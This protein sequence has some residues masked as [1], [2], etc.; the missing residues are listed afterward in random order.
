MDHAFRAAYTRARHALARHRETAL[1]YFD[2]KVA[3]VVLRAAELAVEDRL[4]NDTKTRPTFRVVSAPTGSGKTSCTMAFIAAKLETDP[5]FSAAII[6]ETCLNCDDVYCDLVR[7]V[8][9]EAVSVWTT[10]H[11]V[12]TD[13]RRERTI[14][15]KTDE[16][17]EGAAIKTRR[18]DLLQAR[19]AICTHAAWEAEMETERNELRK[20]R[21]P[22]RS[23]RGA[24]HFRD[25]RRTVLFVDEKPSLSRLFEVQSRHV[26]DLKDALRDAKN[27]PMQVA[28]LGTLYARMEEAANAPQSYTYVPVT[29]VTP[30]EAEVFDHFSEDLAS[31]LS[32]RSDDRANAFQELVGFIKTAALGNV[33][34]SQQGI[35]GKVSFV[36]YKLAYDQDP[37]IVLLDATADLD[38]YCVLSEDFARVECPKARYDNMV[39]VN[40]LPPVLFSK[41]T[42]YIDQRSAWSEYGEWAYRLVMDHTE[43]GER[44]LVIVHKELVKQSE[45]WETTFDDKRTLDFEGRSI[46]CITWGAGIGLNKWTKCQKVFAIGEFIPPRSATVAETEAQRRLK[47]ELEELA[48]AQGRNFTGHYLLAQEGH[49][50]RWQVQLAL[51]G[52][53]R[54]LDEEGAASKMTLFT[55]MEPEFLDKHFRRMFPGAA[56][57]EVLDLADEE[58][59]SKVLRLAK[60]LRTTDEDVLLP[61]DVTRWAGVKD[62]GQAI[63]TSSAV[64]AAM[65]LFGW[66]YVRPNEI[67]MTGRAMLLVR[68]DELNSVSSP[69]ELPHA[70]LRSSRYSA[71]LQHDIETRA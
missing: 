59:K 62:L 66:R 63:K 25:R 46:S 19:V 53:A 21:R 69:R 60:L 18:E 20:R 56:P 14:L 43:P 26:A 3:D 58:P 57:P 44:A 50:L 8:G 41:G 45:L 13:E 31:K 64:Q 67:G 16:R 37:G 22:S 65:D 49:R 7:L 11:D 9:P 4:L 33:F 17:E 55:T 1:S 23:I 24:R 68:E 35:G 42:R 15:N 34:M 10:A 70:N 27:S 47:A 29:L 12:K 40:V 5:D 48:K 30:E 6:M 54:V 39:V 32:P 38:S 2:D 71:P 52:S 61:G 28:L 51:R 36:A